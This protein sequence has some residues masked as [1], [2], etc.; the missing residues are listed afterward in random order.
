MSWWDIFA[1]IG[2]AYAG[3]FLLFVGVIV[4][5]LTTDDNMKR[6]QAPRWRTSMT[7]E[8]NKAAQEAK[9][10]EAR[11]ELAALL[12]GWHRLEQGDDDAL[13]ALWLE[14]KKAREGAATIAGLEASVGHLS[15]LVDEQLRLIIDVERECGHD[16]YGGEFEDGESAII[17]RCRAHI[18]AMKT[19]EAAPAAQPPARELI[20]LPVRSI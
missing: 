19:P 10:W 17:D 5:M 9:E 1:S 6:R 3:G 8:S 7:T 2:I 20:D 11:G 16:V 12:K 14:A 15:A 13:V 18:A 4:L